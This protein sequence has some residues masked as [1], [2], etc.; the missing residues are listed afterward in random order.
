MESQHNSTPTIEGELN[1]CLRAFVF[2]GK[3]AALVE[4]YVCAQI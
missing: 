1:V 4:G 3:K 2:K